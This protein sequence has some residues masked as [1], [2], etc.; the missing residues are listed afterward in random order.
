MDPTLAGQDRDPDFARHRPR[1]FA[2][3]EFAQQRHA[4]QH[5]ESD[6]APFVMHPI[7]VATILDGAGYLDE[8]IAAGVLHDVLENTDT[9]PREITDRFGSDVAVLVTA[10]TED[11]TIENDA[12]RKA[13]L[14][15]QVARAGETAAAVFAAD[16]ISKVR[17]LSLRAAR[18]P[19]DPAS[20]EKLAHYEASLEM[21]SEEMPGHKL[22]G[23]LR[24]S[25]EALHAVQAGDAQGSSRNRRA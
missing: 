17:E 1:M 12:D 6:H 16:K 11:P 20:R 4:G 7:E 21:L 23:Q 19:L 13:A 18:G 15:V 9:T 25:L 24:Q 14:R 2:A 3:L 5:R 10:V 8:V 22:V